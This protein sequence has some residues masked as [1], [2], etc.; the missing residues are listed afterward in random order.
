MK[1][2]KNYIE[3]ICIMSGLAVI[4]GTTFF[5]S[6]IIGA[7]TLGFVLFGLGAYFTKYPIEKRRGS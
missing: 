1:F 7:Y 2:I 3:D 4:V 6:K 5:I